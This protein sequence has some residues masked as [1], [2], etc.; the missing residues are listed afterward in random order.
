MIQI[1]KNYTSEFEDLIKQAQSMQKQFNQNLSNN[2]SN[3]TTFTVYENVLGN[4]TKSVELELESNKHFANYISSGNQS[5]NQKSIDL[6]S[7]AFIYENKML[8]SYKSLP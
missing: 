5:E 4:F 1:T 2:I 8:E 3:T 6:L 7:K